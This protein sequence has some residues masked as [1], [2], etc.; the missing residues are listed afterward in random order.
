MND[1]SEMTNLVY[2]PKQHIPF[3]S[4]S[5]FPQCYYNSSD[6]P[7]QRSIIAFL[8]HRRAGLKPF[9]EAILRARAAEKKGASSIMA[10][11]TTQGGPSQPQPVITA[12]GSS[13]IEKQNVPNRNRRR[14]NPQKSKKADED[15]TNSFNVRQEAGT[16]SAPRQAGFTNAN[17]RPPQPPLDVGRSLA[18]ARNAIRPSTATPG[19]Q[20]NQT[21]SIHTG[22]IRPTPI[23]SASRGSRPAPNVQPRNIQIQQNYT[24]PEEFDA[25]QA[26]TQLFTLLTSAPSAF[27]DS[28][29]PFLTAYAQTLMR[30]DDRESIYPPVLRN[31]TQFSRECYTSWQ[32]SLPP[33]DVQET[34]SRI[35]WNINE[36]VASR[37]PRLRFVVE[38]FGSVSWRGETGNGGGDIDLVLRDYAR[39]LGYTE[40]YWG[41]GGLSNMKVPSVYNTNVMARTLRENGYSDVEP[42][43]WAST[44]IGQSCF[45]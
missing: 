39:P 9:S 4:H 15:I 13:K 29:E 3:S 30:P 45:L 20:T 11:H 1:R 32:H 37:W 26:N 44:P 40:E 43:R 6:S 14:P 16:S 24:G 19:K 23:A 36:V 27:L 25:V 28:E 10:S 17:P 2:A 33:Q 34:V 38:P 22:P 18:A 7:R 41:E 31:V 12:S 5:C 21:A 35:V 42:I 8:L